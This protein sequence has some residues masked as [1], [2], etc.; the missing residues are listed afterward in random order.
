M[1]EV[2]V[3][4]IVGEEV[5]EIE[6]EEGASR[7][8]LTPTPP[9]RIDVVQIGPEE[10]MAERMK[11][12]PTPPSGP[13]PEPISLGTPGPWVRPSFLKQLETVVKTPFKVPEQ[14]PSFRLSISSPTALSIGT[15]TQGDPEV[16]GGMRSADKGT[17]TTSLDVLH[18][19]PPGSSHELVASDLLEIFLQQLP[20]SRTLGDARNHR[21]ERHSS[22]FHHSCSKKGLTLSKSLSALKPRSHS[23]SH[24]ARKSFELKLLLSPLFHSLSAKQLENTTT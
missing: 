5:R 6:E 1:R 3:E 22:S 16:S 10:Q 9:A 21:L 14:G 13:T 15:D 11:K 23:R 18:L 2:V 12:L 24:R 17:E 19:Q 4:S 7:D 8:I 20:V